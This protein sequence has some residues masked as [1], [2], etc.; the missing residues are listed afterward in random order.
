MAGVLLR[1]RTLLCWTLVS[2]GVL[3]G[4]MFTPSRAIAQCM[5]SF[6]NTMTMAPGGSRCM[7]GGYMIQ[8]FY[9]D[10]YE[11]GCVVNMATNVFMGTGPGGGMGCYP[12]ATTSGPMTQFFAVAAVH[13]D[14]SADPPL[15]SIVCDCGPVVLS[16]ATGLPVELMDFTVK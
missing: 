13:C 6:M 14:G 9:F 2:V 8:G 3:L 10:A 16:G 4:S 11:M 5:G 1:V 12:R 7:G 15:C